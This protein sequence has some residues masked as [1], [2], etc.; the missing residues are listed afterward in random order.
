MK[1]FVTAVLVGGLMTL[2]AVALGQTQA[3][4]PLAALSA[5]DACRTAGVSETRQASD[6][7]FTDL[8]DTA[9]PVADAVRCLV[10]LGVV[11]GPEADAED[12][13]FG[14]RVA[15][16]AAWLN[17]R[18][19]G[20]KKAGRIVSEAEVSTATRGDF[21]VAIDGVLGTVADGQPVAEIGGTGWAKFV[22][23]VRNPHPLT[24]AGTI[25]SQYAA[26]RKLYETRI[27]L[28]YADGTF[29]PVKTISRGEAALMIR[30]ALDYV[31][32]RPAGVSI[33]MERVRTDSG[34]GELVIFDDAGSV[35]LVASV[36]DGFVP[37]K[38]ARVDVAVV[39]PDGDVCDDPVCEI[40]GGDPVTG[41]DGDTPFSVNVSD[42]EDGSR[43][44]VWTGELGDTFSDATEY[45][46]VV[47]SLRPAADSLTVEAGFVREG[48]RKAK[49]GETVQVVLTV[50]DVNGD[51][52]D[53]SGL[54]ASVIDN[55]DITCH[56]ARMGADDTSNSG[57]VTCSLGMGD[58]GVASGTLEFVEQKPAQLADG[59]TSTRT[60][61]ITVTGGLD[62]AAA[63]GEDLRV[64]P[65]DGAIT[66]DGGLYENGA[67][68]LEWLE[69]SGGLQLDLTA[70]RWTECADRDDLGYPW[71]CSIA[72]K[73]GDGATGNITVTTTDD[74]GNTRGVEATVNLTSL[75]DTNGNGSLGNRETTAVRPNGRITL[76][77]DDADGL[78]EYFRA[79]IPVLQRGECLDA[80]NDCP[81][82]DARDRA[83]ITAVLGFYWASKI[84]RGSS[85]DP[86]IG[87]IAFRGSSNVVFSHQVN[88]NG[89][90]LA[91]IDDPDTEDVNE[92]EAVTL[93]DADMTPYV[94]DDG[95]P[96]Y[97]RVAYSADFTGKSQYN[98]AGA[99]STQAEWVKALTE[100]NGVNFKYERVSVTPSGTHLKFDLLAASSS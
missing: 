72:S 71:A 59:K 70:G 73:E 95:N 13:T 85:G 39:A 83:E 38:D 2:G 24:D 47:V 9:A 79:Q 5:A 90:P 80:G 37:V 60:V 6:T 67:I 57:N 65:A 86:I 28:G 98:I 36:F 84:E 50:A 20:M 63:D 19:S 94:D 44:R 52:V 74:F 77:R 7:G 100:K 48:A 1:P 35:D 12:T 8:D 33:Y 54:P 78:V 53:Y 55:Y 45:A 17:G 43:I 93:K 49:F 23:P 82:T 99:P 11:E 31:N 62:L 46:E 92:T 68:G 81:E 10:A 40:D 27:T 18:L 29:K 41:S 4:P 61:T 88:K 69:A 21:A 3:D 51:P 87:D 91:E 42:I 64:V 30:R 96:L 66:F 15:A 97:E 76:T 75:N 16:D 22:L 34:N 56:V 89:Q 32:V 25:Q 58:N 14:A 26:I